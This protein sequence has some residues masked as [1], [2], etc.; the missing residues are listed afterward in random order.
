MSDPE[1]WCRAGL[2]GMSMRR[3]SGGTSLRY[4]TLPGSGP[5]GVGPGCAKSKPRYPP[6]DSGC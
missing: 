4:Q 5:P 6:L 2:A 3:I 1:R